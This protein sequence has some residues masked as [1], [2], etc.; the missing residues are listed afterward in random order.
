MGSEGEFDRDGA[1]TPRAVFTYRFN[2]L[3]SAAGDPKLDRVARAA[4]EVLAATKAPGA[5]ARIPVQRLSDW[6]NGSIPA[7]WEMLRPALSVLI[8]DA[9]T[10]KGRVPAEL[11]DMGRWERWWTAADTWKTPVDSDC[12]YQGLKPYGAGDAARYVGR[13]QAIG[14]LAGLVGDAS[15]AGG[16]FVVMVGASGVGKS[17]LLAA[18]L[19]PALGG[20]WVVSTHTAGNGADHAIPDTAADAEGNTPR[21]LIVDQGERLFVDGVGE[22]ER[23]GFVERLAELVSHGWVVVFAVRADFF[24]ACLEIPALAEGF[25]TRGFVLTPMRRDELVRVVTEPAQRA[26]LSLE[27]GLVELILTEL[28]GMDTGGR[29]H[30]GALPLLSHVLAV[31]WER[32]KGRK[33]TVAAYQG[34]GGVTGAVARTAEG[35]WAKLA[36]SQEVTARRMLVGMVAVGDGARDTRRRVS[37]PDLLA[38]APDA[39]R[40]LEAFV[41]ARLVTVDDGSAELAHDVVIGAWSRLRDW[42]DADRETHL[43]R[44]R[45]TADAAAWAASGRDPARLYR[46]LPLAQARAHLGGDSDAVIAEFLAAA[47][48]ARQRRRRAQAAIAAVVI[49]ALVAAATAAVRAAVTARERDAVF[50]ATVLAEAD[51]LQTS[52]PTLSAELDVL[53]QRLRPGDPRVVTRLIAS[54]NL[55]VASTFI[56][57]PGTVEWLSYLDDTHLV[58]AGDDHAIRV[59]ASDGRSV[60]TLAAPPITDHTDQVVTLATHA[61]LLVSGSRDGTVRLRDL[62]DLAQPRLL[63]TLTESAPPIATALSADGRTLAVASTATVELWDVSD[64][65]QPIRTTTL[66]PPQGYFEKIAFAGP[67]AFVAMTTLDT[68]VFSHTTAVWAWPRTREGSSDPIELGRVSD[69]PMILAAN[70]AVPTVAMAGRMSTQP[71]AG[72]AQLKVLD[73]ADPTHPAVVAPAVPLTSASDLNGMALSRNGRV[74]AI[75][76]GAETR[77]FDL[78]DP[79]HPAPLGPPLAG[80]SSCREVTVGCDTTATALA[81]NSDATQVTLAFPGGRVQRWS[82]PVAALAGQAGQIQRPAISGDGTRMLTTAH[83]APSHLWDIHDPTAPRLLGA[84]DAPATATINSTSAI[85]YPTLSADGRIAVYPADGQITLFDL[86]DPTAPKQ[87]YRFPDALGAAFLPDRPVLLV[88]HALPVPGITLFDCTDPTQPRQ[89][90]APITLPPS[91]RALQTGLEPALSRDG[92]VAASIADSLQI[93]DTDRTLHAHAGPVGGLP[94]D[95][96]GNGAGLAISDDHHTVVAGWDGGTIRVFDITDPKHI[97]PLGEPVRV[98]HTIVTGVALS[99][100]HLLTSGADATVRLFDFTDP[101]HPTPYGD[102]IAPPGPTRWQ[103]A[104]HPRGE[105]LIGAADQ[106]ALRIWDLNPDHANTRTCALTATTITDDLTTY[107]PGHALPRLCA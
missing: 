92:A 77:L 42:I 7:R 6:K 15:A 45:V 89:L 46:G 75:V 41:A 9:G 106:G 90:T 14:K 51:R 86:T 37:R 29:D 34:A 57:H 24:D 27:P 16:G 4:S 61:P 104:S 107:L 26:G 85:S 73:L 28:A 93:W 63:H 105:Y 66:L 32:R 65:A 49:V 17:S 99:G 91:P 72:D 76:S 67:G 3:W 83:G 81:W 23:R 69:G 43:V 55:P 19:I 12:P 2:Q 11:L 84:I 94:L 88:L 95:W 52:D 58:A 53:A 78:A 20:D 96:T 87:S 35:V 13:E 59:W 68:G 70:P 71:L 18:G 10:R 48:R 79:A 44:Q 38:A 5:R 102:S 50:F 101:H 1:Q 62:S 103:L 98:S 60:P 33:L 22:T 36:E 100:H 31:T 30:P 56:D 54:E 25:D 82:V 97:A 39:A 47:T 21:V 8:A 64:P 80:G 74:L 40:I